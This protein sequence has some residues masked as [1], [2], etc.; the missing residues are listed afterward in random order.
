MVIRWLMYIVVLALTAILAVLYPD[1]TSALLFVGVLCY[2][3]VAWA[4]LMLHRIFLTVSPKEKASL[5]MVKKEA[6][7]DVLF[8]VSNRSLLPVW[9]LREDYRINNRMT[10][11]KLTERL[12]TELEPYARLMRKLVIVPEHYGLYELEKG[13]VRLSDMF[14]LLRVKKKLTA[15]PLF[16]CMP[17]IETLLPETI[18]SVITE[19]IQEVSARA[20]KGEEQPELREIREFQPGDRQNRIHQRLSARFEK[21]MVR[22]LETEEKPMLLLIPKLY[23]DAPAENDRCLEFLAALIKQCLLKG[24]CSAVWLS[25]AQILPAGNEEEL[26]HVFYQLLST[27][28]FLTVSKEGD[29]LESTAELRDIEQKLPAEYQIVAWMDGDGITYQTR[30]GSAFE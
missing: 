16:F 1:Y 11:E 24:I 30:G 3:A 17:F 7:C 23:Q 19:L 12:D 10:G 6:P 21:T 13:Q 27:P 18:S 2:P 28:R 9:Q 29:R 15:Q 14:R 26:N 5:I 4:E 22:V 25:E 20:N 8:Q